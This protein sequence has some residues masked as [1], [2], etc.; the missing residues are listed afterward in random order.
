MVEAPASTAAALVTV[1]DLADSATAEAF[2]VAAALA[3]FTTASVVFEVEALTDSATAPSL[4]ASATLGTVGALRSAR[5]R[6][7]IRGSGALPILTTI[8][9]ITI[10][11]IA[12]INDVTKMVLTAIVAV[13][14]IVTQTTVAPTNRP[15]NQIVKTHGRSLRVLPMTI[16]TDIL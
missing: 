5:G 14:T 8:R 12:I 1:A 13:P 15:Q 11:T 16:G 4:A 10:P 6:I 9:T 2:A 7:G 3:V